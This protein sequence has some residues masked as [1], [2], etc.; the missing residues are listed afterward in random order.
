MAEV[1]QDIPMLAQKARFHPVPTR[2]ESIRTS[3]IFY[4][5]LSY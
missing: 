4:K 1:E 5:Q 3:Y 2:K